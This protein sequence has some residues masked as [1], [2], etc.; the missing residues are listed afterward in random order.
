MNTNFH[1]RT[2]LRTR[3]WTMLRRVLTGGFNSIPQVLTSK[4]NSFATARCFLRPDVTG[5]RH[6]GS[7]LGWFS[8]SST[9]DVRPLQLQLAAEGKLPFFLANRD[10]RLGVR[11]LSLQQLHRWTAPTPA[12]AACV[13]VAALPDLLGTSD[14]SSEL[15]TIHKPVEQTVMSCHDSSYFK[16]VWNEHKDL[17]T[18][19][20]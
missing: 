20:V 2:H 11:W 12:P 1:A 19:S 15:F 4:E 14:I 6:S 7:S 3:T 18:V 13:R 9:S 16:G 5:V 10:D 8:L 17:N